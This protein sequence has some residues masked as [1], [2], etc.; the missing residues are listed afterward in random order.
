[1]E[2][3]RV[4]ECGPQRDDDRVEAQG[5]R[6]HRGDPVPRHRVGDRTAV[7]ERLRSGLFAR[8]RVD[9]GIR[10]VGEPRGQRL[11]QRVL[12]LGADPSWRPGEQVRQRV[13][14]EL[15]P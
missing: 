7:G 8:K 13:E 2:R 6:D 14:G 5:V 12:H 10:L 11:Q 3:T 1:M 4:G 9:T 15:E